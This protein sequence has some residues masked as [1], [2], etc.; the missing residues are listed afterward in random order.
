MH[1]VTF[2]LKQSAVALG[3]YFKKCDDADKLLRRY[4]AWKSDPDACA[5]TYNT[6]LPHLLRIEDDW[7]TKA[8]IDFNDVSSCNTSDIVKREQQNGDI[9][10]IKYKGQLST[11][12]RAMTD[13]EIRASNSIQPAS[14]LIHQ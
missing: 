6:A 10:I 12:K 8:I 3:F 9:E 14:S 4:E 5:K 1:S 13:S 2:T 7:D 11:K